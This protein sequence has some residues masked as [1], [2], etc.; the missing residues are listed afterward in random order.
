MNQARE[1]GRRLLNGVR[2]LMDNPIARKELQ[3]FLRVRGNLIA[4]ALFLL[5]LFFIALGFIQAEFRYGGGQNDVGTAYL[6]TLVG[7]LAVSMVIIVP[8]RAAASITQ[9]K[10]KRTMDLLLTTLLTPRE[11]ISGKLF[12]PLGLFAFLFLLALPFFP[13]GF[14]LGGV[15]PWTLFWITIWLTLAVLL[16]SA[17]AILLSS[18]LDRTTTVT[19]MIFGVGFALWI[20]V[21]WVIPLIVARSGSSPYSGSL[22]Y[23]WVALI[24]WGIF[25]CLEKAADNLL[26][27]TVRRQ[28]QRYFKRLFLLGYALTLALALLFLAGA[29]GSTAGMATFFVFFGFLHLLLLLPFPSLAGLPRWELFF[30][31]AVTA[32]GL[33][34]TVL[35]MAMTKSFDL[36]VRSS[37]SSFMIFLDVIFFSQ[38]SYLLSLTRKQVERVR[39]FLGFLCGILMFFSLSFWIIWMGMMGSSYQ[40]FA[41][42][43]PVYSI[44]NVW[45]VTGVGSAGIPAAVRSLVFHGIVMAGLILIVMVFIQSVKR[46]QIKKETVP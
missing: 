17:A 7:I 41:E 22:G 8:S 9:E 34:A 16:I 2:Q 33:L 31:P 45:N 23:L 12:Y 40:P 5:I 18:Y 32:A 14:F 4:L 25:F 46:R 15:S 3:I 20:S 44:V 27:E 38:L 26:P 11:I 39:R 29:S 13:L 43:L 10:E 37:L 35:V 28:H 19:G 42:L 1:W 6:W 36:T 24:L 30:T 21:G